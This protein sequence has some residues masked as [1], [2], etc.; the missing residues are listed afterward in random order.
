MIKSFLITLGIY[1]LHLLLK[2]WNV[3]AKKT[4]NKVDDFISKFFL[5][6]FK[7]ITFKKK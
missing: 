5:E 4:E 6:L 7:I 2:R 3:Y 1:V